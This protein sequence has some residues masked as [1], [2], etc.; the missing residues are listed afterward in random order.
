[1]TDDTPPARPAR[2]ILLAACAVAAI[3]LLVLLLPLQARSHRTA[4]VDRLMQAAKAKD[5]PGFAALVTPRGKLWPLFDVVSP[6]IAQTTREL[7]GDCRPIGK[8]EGIDTVS[9]EFDCA[10]DANGQFF[11]DFTFCGE[12]VHQVRFVE[13]G[14]W[15]RSPIGRDLENRALDLVNG[16]QGLCSTSG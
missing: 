6:L 1:M 4:V 16:D 13:L 2:R 12:K 8:E 3:A 7:I 10:R 9:V 15:V 5:E 11:V 14:R